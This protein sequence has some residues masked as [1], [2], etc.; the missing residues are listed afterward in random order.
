VKLH[1]IDGPARWVRRFVAACV[2]LLLALPA[3]GGPVFERAVITSNPSGET[4]GGCCGL[5]QGG[6][7]TATNATVRDLIQSAHQRYG[8]D[9]REIEGGPAWI[10]AKR[11]DVVAEAAEEHVVDPDGVP[12]KTWLMLQ[13][14]LAERFKLKLRVEKR[15]RPL[16][17]LALATPDGPLG[18]RLR[19]SDVDCARSWRWRSE[20]SDRPSPAAPSPPILAAW[21]RRRSR[22]RR[23]RAFSRTAW[24]ARSAT[25]RGLPASSTSSS[26][27]SK[28]VRPA[29]SGPSYRP[30][31]TKESI[32]QALR[33][34]QG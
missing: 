1:G 33:R 24:T 7:L 8:F 10:Q 16:Y 31:D 2:V 11:F 21:S 34:R 22:C 29:P 9:R 25:R 23:S 14:L 30:S 17:V 6:R 13:A 5:Q 27:L 20:D 3:V 28:S 12:R 32:F 15:L 18:P 4:M 26:R 19:R